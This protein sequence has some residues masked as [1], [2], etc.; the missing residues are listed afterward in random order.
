MR[1]GRRRKINTGLVYNRLLAIMAHTTRYAFKGEARLAAD[2]RVARSTISRLVTGQSNPSFA[3]VT[4]VSQALSHHL[5]RRID[6]HEFISFDG[7]YPTPSVCQLVGCTGCLPSEVYT[8]NGHR[9]DE[10]RD[11]KPG[12]WSMTDGR[13]VPASEN[14]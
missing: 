1:Q 2:A 9:K 7:L 4:A 12:Q 14:K 11:I 5:S 10:Y 6:P 3:L 13:I 8:E